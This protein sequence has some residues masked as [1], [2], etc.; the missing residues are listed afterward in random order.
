MHTVPVK[1][2]PRAL[3]Q[4]GYTLLEIAFTMLVIGLFVAAF[5]P[6][7]KLYLDKTRYE[8]TLTTQKEIDIALETFKNLRGRYPCPAPE[9]AVPGSSSYGKETKCYGSTVAPGTCVSGICYELSERTF[10][11]NGVDVTPRVERGAVPFLTLGIPEEKSYDAYHARLSY[12]VTEILTSSKTFKTDRGGIEIMDDSDPTPNS[13]LVPKASGLYFVFS[14]GPDNIGAYDQYGQQMTLCKG[15]MFDNENCNT[16]PDHPNARY[17]HARHSTEAIDDPSGGKALPSGTPPKASNVNTHFDDFVNYVGIGSSNPLWETTEDSIT[18][19]A[20][21]TVNDHDF[22]VKKV[23]FSG[24]DPGIVDDTTDA[25]S[26]TM[27]ARVDG[28]AI[29]RNGVPRL[30]KICD[31]NS[32]DATCM[33]SV[34]MGAKDPDDVRRIQ[35]DNKGQYPK[36]ISN[37]QINCG[38]LDPVV[39]SCASGTVLTGFDNGG[40]PICTTI[41]T[42]KC[43][44]TTKSI[45]GVSKVL[46]DKAANGTIVV[47][48]G[49]ASYSR[50]YTC[51]NK[52]WVAG[53]ATGVC[54]CT[55]GSTTTTAA[56]G[57]NMSGNATTTT[58]T[59]CP[60]GQTSTTTNRSQCVCVPSSVNRTVACPTGYNGS[61][62]Y[63]D[64]VTCSGGGP[65]SSTT[66]TSNTCTCTVRT[67]QQDVACP[68]GFS[69]SIRQ[70]RATSCPSNSFGAWGEISNTCKCNPSYVQTLNCD[71]SKYNVGSITQTCS[72]DCS[73]GTNQNATLSCKETAN[74]CKCVAGTTTTTKACPSGYTGTIKVTSETS[75]PSNTTK[76]TEDDSQ[77]QPIQ[78]T[79]QFVVNNSTVLGN[80]K[81]T[82][83]AGETCTY[84]AKDDQCTNKTSCYK[85]VG[86]NSYN[87][88]SCSCQ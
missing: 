21:D 10:P 28:Q 29:V 62:T 49:G 65:T 81:T 3:S 30:D 22:A 66:Q 55:A 1:K 20:L 59:I 4:G 8:E 45:C 71:S 24:A 79:C 83:M 67:E 9:D 56:C 11:V 63:N 40:L 58:T 37:S 31:A 86:T 6:L 78:M 76:V 84:T 87:A 12:A 23:V 27:L 13:M 34:L 54:N 26:A 14:H 17:R 44:T 61:I 5:V 25:K 39:V 33:A 47:L 68:S 18:G 19:N 53:T 64:K 36:G 51:T 82:Y 7:Y 73:K 35:C 70:Q 77:C 42:D 16:S 48:T 50:P 43:A 2:H 52:T 69:G 15:S 57:T 60:S 46:P 80:F 88:Y 41:T 85:V 75:C 38:G 72:Y 74:T 32:T